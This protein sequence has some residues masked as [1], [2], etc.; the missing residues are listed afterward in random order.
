MLVAMLK[1]LVVLF[2]VGGLTLAGQEANKTR[3]LT[4]RSD[5][6][7]AMRR[8]GAELESVKAD[9]S[10]S[11]QYVFSGEETLTGMQYCVEGRLPLVD[12]RH[13]YRVPAGTVGWLSEDGLQ[14]VLEQCVNMAQCT[15]CPPV[16]TPPAPAP[17][18]APAEPEVVLPPADTPVEVKELP[19]PP[20]WPEVSRYKVDLVWDEHH[21]DVLKYIPCVG[22]IVHPTKG[23]ALYCGIAV[24]GIATWALWP[25]A[26]A[27][28]TK[29]VPPLGVISPP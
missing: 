4:P 24:A 3:L 21:R 14:V 7:T 26:T 9:H 20:D 12:D 13:A 2:S 15:G 22:L 8:C 5:S 17:P 1:Y 10:L 18:P 28:G 23:R 25:G 19:P 11:R 27:V 6:P 16:P 29:I